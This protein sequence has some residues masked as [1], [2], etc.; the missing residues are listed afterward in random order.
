M[1]TVREALRRLFGRSEP[2]EAAGL[3]RAAYSYRVYWTKQARAW[4]A[5]RRR[6]VLEAVR[7]V[8]TAETFEPN[9]FERR[10]RAEGLAGEH[11]GASLLALI[12]V[13]EALDAVE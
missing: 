7:R 13:L 8:T 10:Y 1:T 6:S 9:S 2:T 4:D 11:S 12:Q 3:D 5:A